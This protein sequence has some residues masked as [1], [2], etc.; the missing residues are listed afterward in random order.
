MSVDLSVTGARVKD[1]GL[2]GA[3]ADEGPQVNDSLY[4][5]STTGGVDSAGGIDF[6]IAV[7]QGSGGDAHGKLVSSSSDAIVGI[8][9]RAPQVMSANPASPI[10]AWPSKHA[11]SVK[12]IGRMFA[13][14]CED[15]RAR[16]QVLAIVSQGGKLAGSKGGVAGSD[17]LNVPNA[18]WETTTSANQVGIVRVYDRETPVLTT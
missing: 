5:E 10:V 1:L 16:D 9:T 18:I 7:A 8:S 12:R 6:G 15:V 4:N 17:R 3:D 11:M 13:V 14:P 2:P